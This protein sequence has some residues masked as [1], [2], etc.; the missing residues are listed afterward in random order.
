[1]LTFELPQKMLGVS[2]LTPSRS[3]GG[4]TPQRGGR[5]SQAL[6]LAK[7]LHF[8]TE[9]VTSKCNFLSFRE[10]YAHF[11]TA[12]YVYLARSKSGIPRGCPKFVTA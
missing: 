2:G 9:K 7:K 3:P 11:C 8:N 6:L 4:P 12:L 10:V 1:M 5:E